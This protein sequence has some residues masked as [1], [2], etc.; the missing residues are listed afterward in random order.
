MSVTDVMDPRCTDA[1]INQYSCTGLPIDCWTPWITHPGTPAFLSIS[2]LVL[3]C[4]LPAGHRGSRISEHRRYFQS[5]LLY[6]IAH[7]LLDTVDHVSRNTTLLSI[8]TLVLDC[9]LPT[10]HCGSRILEPQGYFV[11]SISTLVL[12]CH[13]LAGYFGSSNLEPWHSHQ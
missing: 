5:V 3:D 2:A 4:P 1:H 6:W 12:D 9:L 7:C 11:F 8:S 13:R 10:G